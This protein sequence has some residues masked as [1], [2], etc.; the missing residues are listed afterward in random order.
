M[1]EINGLVWNLTRRV[2]SSWEGKKEL[3]GE[4]LECQTETVGTH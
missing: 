3:V 4:I 1:G 2:E